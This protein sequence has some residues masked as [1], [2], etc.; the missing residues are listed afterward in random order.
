MGIPRVWRM[1][2]HRYRLIGSKCKK[3]GKVYAAIRQ[4]CPN[5]GSR[6]ME[7]IKFSGK[8]KIYSYTVIHAAQEGFELYTPYVVGIIELEEGAKITAQIVDCKPE[9]L[10]IGTPVEAV[11]R[12]FRDEIDRYQVDAGLRLYGYKFRPIKK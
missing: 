5:C 12:Y 4:V 10:E 6:E 2:K 11:F 7:E 1:M 3:C 8:G 9:E